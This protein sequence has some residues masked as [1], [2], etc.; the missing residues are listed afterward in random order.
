MAR[1]NAQKNTQADLHPLRLCAPFYSAE[2]T[3]Y[4]RSG[5]AELH[6]YFEPEFI[7]RF[8]RDLQRR[9]LSAASVEQWK[10]E[11]RFSKFDPRHVVLRLP[12]HK[13]F[14]VVSCE[15]VCDRLGYPALDPQK[16]K[17][18]GFVIRRRGSS[19]EQSWMLEDDQP[20]G[21]EAAPAGQRDPDVNRRLC[22]GKAKRL[23][24]KTAASEEIT[25]YTGEQSHP[26]HPLKV[27]DAEGKCHTILHGYLPLG[28]T[29][30]FRQVQGKAPF[31]ESSLADFQRITAAQLL[32]PF[33]FRPAAGDASLNKTWLE[34]HTRSV[35]AGRATASF[36]ELLKMLVNRYHL[37]EANLSENARL[38]EWAGR[39]YFYSEALNAQLTP[40]NFSDDSRASFTAAR[41]YSLLDW[42]SAFFSEGNNRLI[43]FLAAQEKAIEKPGAGYV[44]GP[45]PAKNA[46]GS[47]APSAFYLTEPDAQELRSLLDQ[48]V[49][50]QALLKVNEIPLP[51]FT[52]GADDLYQV[53]PFVRVEDACGKEQVVWAGTDAR[54][55]L[56]RVAAPFDPNASRPSLIQ[57]PSLSD[58]KAGLAKGVSMITPPDTFGLMN[59]L[60]LKK[61][62]SEDVLPSGAPVSVGIQ[63]ICSFSLPVITLVA[64]IL[65]MIMI[66]LLNI[67]FFWLPFVRI[68]LPFPSIKKP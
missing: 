35:S 6:R 15:I 53:I 57:M 59:A 58:L 28:G 32:W 1:I 42:L 29:Y 37:G 40:A 64:M 24:G 44:Y 12:M 23:A 63:W 4:S 34:E 9:Q 33:G 19:G 3:H 25:T 5:Q 17:S 20:L 47:G 52:Q 48:R 18:A 31:D 8:Q 11:D 61:G 43:E 55:E 56:F 21:W 36:F 10:R 27:W 41:Q 51:K 62:A 22:C 16:I 60:N 30:L 67:V 66:S 68:C 39:Q 13:S 14:Y 50:D 38:E 49:L 65:L 2:G 26:L 54:S 45:L 7:A 46:D